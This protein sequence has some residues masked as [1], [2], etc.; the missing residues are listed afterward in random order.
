MTDQP[1][2]RRKTLEELTREEWE[3]LCD[4]CARCCLLKL[5][6]EEKGEVHLTRLVCRM[7]DAGSCRC[8]DYANRHTLMPDCIEIDPEKV[9]SLDWLP[10]SCSYRLVAEGKDLHWWHHLVSGSRETVHEAG[11]SVRGWTTSEAKVK[12]EQM[13]RY[14]IKDYGKPSGKAASSPKMKRPAQPAVPEPS[15]GLAEPAGT[16]KAPRPAAT[17]RVRNRAR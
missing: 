10:V 5:E 15:D 17:S 2:W 6:D 7:L 11:V 12:A 1:F 14:I 13:H 4:G 3:Q 9:R 16:P 8:S